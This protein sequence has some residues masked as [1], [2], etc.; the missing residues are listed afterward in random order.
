MSQPGLQL[1]RT[2]DYWCGR[3]QAMASPC[4]ILL[5]C[6]R[7]QQA[8]ELATLAYNEALRIEHKFSRYRSDNIIHHINHAHGQELELDEETAQLLDYAKLCFDLSD[9]RF[10]ITSGIL[11]QAWTFDGSDQLPEQEQITALLHLV[12][13]NKLS[14]QAP[15]LRL[16]AGMEIDLGG[17]AK[18]YAVDRAALLLKQQGM[19]NGLVN[20]GGDLHVLG[21]RCSGQPWQIAVED[22]Q[23]ETVSRGNIAVTQGAMAT[24]GDSHRYLLRDGVRY[25]HILDPRNGWPIPHAPRSVTVIASTCLE[26]GMLATF[27]MLEGDN[28]ENFLRTEGVQHWILR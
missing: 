1:S 14:W 4:E 23:Q 24:S 12:G 3:F 20:F 7:E 5:D 15:K 9:G 16:Q 19:Q 21:P 13:F 18:E 10:D 25:S 8:L 26:A 28:A 6:D 11:R 22:P 2:H 27:A 17:I